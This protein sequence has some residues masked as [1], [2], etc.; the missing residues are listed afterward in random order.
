[1]YIVLN[2]V[3]V[4]GSFMTDLLEEEM[5][6]FTSVVNKQVRE[7]R[8]L[9][10]QT[11][12]EELDSEESTKKISQYLDR[13]KN[14]LPENSTV[15]TLRAEAANNIHLA[16]ALAVNPTR[17]KPHEKEAEKWINKLSK[18]YNMIPLYDYPSFKLPDLGSDALYI[19][20]GEIV[21]KEDKSE[22]NITKALDF[23][24]QVGNT[25]V[26][27]SQKFTKEVGGAQKD[28][29]IEM[30]N[31]MMYAKLN[32]S[33]SMYF[34]A[35]VDGEYYTKERIEFLNRNFGTTRV[36]ALSIND[37]STFIEKLA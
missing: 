26:I 19:E 31:F 3:E 20:E 28:Y 33:P 1:M 29:E 22:N 25:T 37:L 17:Q 6:D 36:V 23:G 7:Q 24:F 15:E 32:K 30:A 34:L 9:N 5:K 2:L 16:I 4:I 14:S 18:K 13:N 8:A 11:F 12:K 35:L 10:V 21:F 27:S